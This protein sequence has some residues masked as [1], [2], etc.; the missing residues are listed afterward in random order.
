MSD[1][2]HV[3]PPLPWRKKNVDLEGAAFQFL[4]PAALASGFNMKET[5]GLLPVSR[6]SSPVLPGA[7]EE[8][9]MVSDSAA[10]LNIPG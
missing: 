4:L 5:L 8:Q 2:I 7:V 1:K 9:E 6:A 3:P 10:L